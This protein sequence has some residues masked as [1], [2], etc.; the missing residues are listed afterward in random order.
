MNDIIS[1]SIGGIIVLIIGWFAS[2]W[3]TII[4]NIFKIWRIYWPELKNN[5]LEILELY[6]N[7]K[8]ECK[9]RKEDLFILY[10]K[11]KNPI[12]LLFIKYNIFPSFDII[13]PLIQFGLIKKKNIIYGNMKE[14]VIACKISIKGLVYLKHHPKTKKEPSFYQFI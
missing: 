6:K 1:G 3:K 7:K 2:K 4:K 10:D 8:N 14:K 12:S 13:E 11:N 9:K 5:Q